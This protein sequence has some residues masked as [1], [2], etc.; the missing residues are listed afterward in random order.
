MI[1]TCLIA[2]LIC[3]SLK[4]FCWGFYGHQKI[5]QYAV[6]LLPL[7]LVKFY[8]P[9]IRW[10][11][12]HSVD[13]DKRRY[14]IREEAPRHYID[15]DRYGKYP[16]DSLPRKWNEAIEKFGEDSITR[17]GIVPWWVNTTYFRLVKAFREKD[18]K[19][20]LR[21]SAELG[22]YASDAHVPLHACSN[23]NG[24]LTGQ[25]G[26][27]GLW[28]SR[29]PE[30][31]ADLKW[32]F[33]ME[34]AQYINNPLGFIWD[35]VL[36]SALASDS[37]LLFEKK[38]NDSFPKDRKFAFEPRNG[39]LARQYSSE[40]CF[41]Y[42]ALLNGMVERRMRQSIHSVASYWYSAWVDAGQP[43]L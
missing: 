30:L 9:H 6:Y 27:H 43:V 19:S 29:I 5:N 8:K 7:E 13:P 15:L 38:L 26:I 12:E 32:D 2:I 4:S 3:V 18:L 14:A 40:Y 37:V 36:E 42:D 28:E 25:H 39:V 41:Q 34:K 1:R 20:I 10:L 17:H 23:Y 22:H 21:H 11:S 33:F 35:R 16:F 31:F 24:Q